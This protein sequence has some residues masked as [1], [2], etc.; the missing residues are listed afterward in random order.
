MSAI[1]TH[2][3]TE[4]DPIPVSALGLPHL[5]VPTPTLTR[6]F[7]QL[8]PTDGLE[9]GTIDTSTYN[10]PTQSLNS[11]VSSHVFE[12]GRR[13][14]AYY[15]QDKN[16]MPTDETEQ[17][18]LDLHHEII[19]ILLNGELYLAPVMNPQRILDIG[20]GTGIWAIDAADK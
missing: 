2:H 1:Q 6:S 10:M 15:G 3:R 19:L 20:T 17:D 16:P 13:Y 18:R 11:S 9:A 4:V 14:H 5:V 7:R 8:G 12:N